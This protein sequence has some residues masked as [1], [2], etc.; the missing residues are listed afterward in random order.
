MLYSPF[1]E[2][3]VDFLQKFKVPAYKIASFENNHIPLVEKLLKQKPI[4]ISTGATYLRE[5]YTI[6][7]LFKKENLKIMLF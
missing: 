1:D 2:S 6:V 4:I 3:A 7:K 5:I